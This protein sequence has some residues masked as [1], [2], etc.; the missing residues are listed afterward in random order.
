M[1]RDYS[2]FYAEDDADDLYILQEVFE[3]YP[4][5]ELRHFNHG[6]ELLEALSGMEPADWPCL[7]L[8]DLNMPQLDGRET[9]IA[10]RRNEKWARIPVFLFTTSNSVVDLRFADNWNVE[11]ITKPLLFDGMEQVARQIVSHCRGR[12]AN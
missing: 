9:L 4:E 10:L 12:L 1:N 8:L 6:G 7:I 5:V 3:A 2:I 11:L